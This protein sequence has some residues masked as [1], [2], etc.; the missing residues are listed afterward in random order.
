MEE[1]AQE[2]RRLV[3]IRSKVLLSEILRSMGANETQYSCH[4]VVDGYVRFAEAT[5]YAARE[6]AEPLL[7]AQGMSTIRSCDAEESAA[8]TLISVIKKECRVEFTDTNWL[9]MNRYHGEMERLK[10]VVGRARK[11]HNTLAK[12]AHLLEIS[13]DRAIDS[14]ASVNQICDDT[15]SSALGGPDADALNH[16]E[17]GVFYDVHRLGEYAQSC[18]DEGLANL[19]SA[20]GRYIQ[21]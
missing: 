9:D 17:V 21:G 4:A 19:T 7:R 3:H 13:W 10:R 11:K 2:Q 15:C 5:I 1:P 18:M 6:G 20:G 14:L 12:K 16:R 8:I